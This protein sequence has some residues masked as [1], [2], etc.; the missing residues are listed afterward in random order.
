MQS[1]ALVEET[2]AGGPSA[3][4]DVVRPGKSDSHV[5]ELDNPKLLRTVAKKY[6]VESTK[7]LVA[8]YNATTVKDERGVL[9]HWLRRYD[10]WK[11]DCL[12]PKH[13]LRYAELAKVAHVSEQD[14]TV[15]RN[16]VYNFGSLIRPNEFLDEDVAKAMLSALTWVESSVYDDTSRLA[17]LGLDLLLSLSSRPRLTRQNFLKYEAN[18]LCIHQV[19]FLLQTIGRGHLLEEEKK[20]LRRIV[21][22]KKEEMELSILYYP[23]SFHFESIQ[24]AV[25]RLEIQDTPSSLRKAKRYAAS[26]LYGTMHVF[27]LL[28]QLTGGDVDPTSIEYAYRRGR[29]ALA[30]AGV[31]EREWYDILQILTAARIRALKEERKCELVVLAYDAAMEGQRKTTREKE[32]KALRYGILQEM[33]LLASDKDFCQDG[34]KKAMAKLVELTTSA[35]ISES[36]IH[37]A[38][39]LVAI[40]DALH[41]IHSIGE[42]NEN[43]GDALRSIQRSCDERT[44]GTLKVW[45]DGNTIEEKLQHQEHADNEY[46]DPFDKI[47]ASVG[48]LHPSTIRSNIEEL[49]RTYLHDNFATVSAIAIVSPRHESCVRVEGAFLVCI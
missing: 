19:F 14:A 42:Q 17:D 2:T 32:Q 10:E 46:E 33:R 47:G 9:L 38:D 29:A 37:D 24:Q 45:L 35:V 1:E 13:V 48:Y 34:R 27:H 6:G 20:R 21:A 26:G 25:E 16:L 8:A 31:S 5:K 30:N 40:L 7:L 43:I 15:L 12:K 44:K 22:Q 41:V 23:V 36:W 39:I 11:D 18:F 4:G 49:K 28:R 3:S